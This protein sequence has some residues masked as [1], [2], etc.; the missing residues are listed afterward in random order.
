MQDLARGRGS[1]HEPLFAPLI[2]AAA[3]Q[4]DATSP[5]NMAVAATKLR[6]N[7]GELRRFLG[8]N[9]TVVAVPGVVELEALGATL[10]SEWPPRPRALPTAL[11]AEGEPP[12]LAS[13]ERLA[14]SLEALEQMKAER[15]EPV[16]LAAFSGPAT[17]LGVVRAAGIEIGAEAA[18][19]CFGRLLAA[20]ARMYGE[21]GLHILQLHEAVA[22][23]REDNAHWNAAL[24]TVGNVARF[25]KVLPVLVVDDAN[26]L[27]GP[28]NYVTCAAQPRHTAATGR[29]CGLAWSAQPAEWVLLPGP[30][31]QARLVTTLGEVAAD[32]PLAELKRHVERIGLPP[33]R[34]HP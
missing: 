29:T 15:D 28:A 17:L 32:L 19:D 27:A 25:H 7:L 1:P 8:L 4:I 13:S 10:S 2:F 12:R 30:Q 9:A 24:L 31:S 21:A 14:A 23:A 26:A 22:P 34:R 11:G 18:Y 3:A 6:K 33:P 20:L 16:L 5:S